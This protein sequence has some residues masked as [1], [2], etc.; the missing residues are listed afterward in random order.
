MTTLT[1]SGRRDLFRIALVSMKT[2]LGAE[3]LLILFDPDE[4]GQLTVQAA[5]GLNPE[6]FQVD[7]PVSLSLLERLRAQGTPW[8]SQDVQQEP[9]LKDIASVLLSGI[10]SVL[11]VPLLDTSQKVRGL[12]YADHCSRPQAFSRGDLVRLTSYARDLERQ[13]WPIVAPAREVPPPPCPQPRG[14]A[15]PIATPRTIPAGPPVPL[16]QRSQVILL[17]S[18]A[19]M[20]GAGLPLARALHV[21][22]G[23]PD[24]GAVAQRMRV[25]VE[26]GQELSAAMQFASPS[27]VPFQLKLIRVGER[28]GG[29]V[30]VL[31]QL[32]DHEERRRALNLRLRSAL[33]YPAALL[34]MCLTLLILGPPFLLKGQLRMLELVGGE[35]PLITRVL[36][37]LS[38][39]R[40]LLLLGLMAV[41]GGV[42]ANLWLRSERGYARF[43]RLMLAIPKLGDLWRLVAVTR[44]SQA[45]ALQLRVGLSVLEAVPQA[46]AATGSPALIAD[47]TR[48]TTALRE[49]SDVT[50][51]LAASDFFPRAFLACLR[52][53]EESG[54]LPDCLQWLSRL[55]Q[56]ELEA[57]LEMA[58]AALE[59]IIMLIMG[60]ATAFVALAT[61]LPMVKVVQSL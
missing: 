2:F 30:E 31:R 34:V 57:A 32:A 12:L 43:D 23:Q 19:V 22:E 10:R 50:D 41:A 46:G 4:S 39:W 7:A 9:E 51:A 36:Y 26:R 16:D 37:A 44:F 61:L 40:V 13:V 18:L 21:L 49:G 6:Q 14:A 25:E 38:D 59:P 5:H 45:L 33:T 20:L 56:L 60:L 8:L 58:L 29:L 27:F 1:D 11:C 53:G 15:R 47:L 48:S 55:N 42:V 35:L 3:R 52:A 24:G 28:T 17:R 54:K